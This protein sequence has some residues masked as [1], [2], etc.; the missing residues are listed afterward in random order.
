M[1][2]VLNLYDDIDISLCWYFKNKNKNNSTPFQKYRYQYCSD[3]RN[4]EFQIFLRNKLTQT[5]KIKLK[6]MRVS[7]TSMPMRIPIK[8][9]SFDVE[10][11]SLFFSSKNMEVCMKMLRFCLS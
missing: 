3:T 2:I 1:N 10:Q 5:F 4:E 9:K 7:Y 8:P 6:K 11:I